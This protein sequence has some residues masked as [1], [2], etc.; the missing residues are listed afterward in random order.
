MSTL[1]QR[2]SGICADNIQSGN[3]KDNIPKAL[4]H[5]DG[6]SWTLDLYQKTVETLLGQDSCPGAS[7]EEL[8]QFKSQF[9]T[10]AYT[11][12]VGSCARATVGFKNH[13]LRDEHE[14][15]HAGGFRCTFP[16][17]QYPPYRSQK[18]LLAH[19]QAVHETLTPRTLRRVPPYQDLSLATRS[20]RKTGHQPVKHQSQTRSKMG[21]ATAIPEPV[22]NEISDLSRASTL[23]EPQNDSSGFPPKPSF[24]HDVGVGYLDIA[25]DRIAGGTYMDPMLYERAKASLLNNMHVVYSLGEIDD[26]IRNGSADALDPEAMISQIWST[27]PQLEQDLKSFVRSSPQYHEFGQ[28]DQDEHNTDLEPEHEHHKDL[29]HNCICGKGNTG[30]MIP[31]Y[32]ASCTKGW[33]HLACVNKV[34]TPRQGENWFCTDTCEKEN[35][36]REIESESEDEQMSDYEDVYADLDI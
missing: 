4:K 16:G 15:C 33:F 12:R 28:K 24:D 31:C 8:E 36:A 14:I 2:Q 13:Q 25:L 9:R 20:S 34:I 3:L 19:K 29:P 26:D 32:N 11:C 17:C 6:I 22:F 10:S 1:K 5:R 23:A 21:P 30:N 27:D 7:R 18:S 35:K